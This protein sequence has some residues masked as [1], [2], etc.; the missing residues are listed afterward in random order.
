[1]LYPGK[2]DIRAFLAFALM[3]AAQYQEAIPHYRAAM[4]L[5]PLYPIWYC[6]GLSTS[7]RSLGQLDEALALADEVLH[8]Q[9][10]HLQSWITRAFVMQE[11]GQQTDAQAAATEIKRI[12][13]NLRTGHLA[14]LF[15]IN[16]P[17][18]IGKIAD[19]LRKAG[20]SD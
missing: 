13:P 2:A 15:I 4:T 19:N 10:G 18:A 3:H 17:E 6:T 1:M 14:N 5:N 11:R 20:L 9:S 16:D 12:A 8:R 7:L